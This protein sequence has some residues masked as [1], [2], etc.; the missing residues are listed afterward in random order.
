MAYTNAIYYLDPDNGVDAR[1]SLSPVTVSN[2]SGTVT[3]CTY[4]GHGL[5]TGAIVTLSS[6]TAWLNGAWR[7]TVVDADNFDL[8]DAE[9]QATA[10]A[11]GTV[12][13]HGGSSKADAWKTVQSGATAARIQP[14]DTIR[15]I[16]SPD[17]VVIGD[18]T[19]T[20]D[21]GE[22]VWTT[23][24]VNLVIDDCETAWTGAT[25]VTASTNTTRRKSGT[26]G[27]S[28]LPATA[29]TTGKI[30]H[31]ALPAT[32][33][34][35]AYQ[36]VSLWIHGGSA[37][38]VAANA[39]TLHLC[40]DAEGDVPIVSL[41]LPVHSSA[42]WAVV[43]L[44]AGAALPSAVASLS[45]SASVDP[46]S[47]TF[48]LDNIV[49]CKAPGAADCVTHMHAIG[50]ATVGEPEWYAIGALTD[51]GATIGGY[52]ASE[53]GSATT[54][55][56]PY[57]GTTETVPTSVLL[58]ITT[59]VASNER[60]IQDIGTDAAPITISGGWDRT[61]MS[62]Q[63]GVTYF[64][65]RHYNAAA[66]DTNNKD[67]L[68]FEKI[69]GLNFTTAVLLNSGGDNIDARLE[70]AVG[71]VAVWSHSSL[72]AGFQRLAFT[73]AHGM[74]IW[75]PFHTSPNPVAFEV[76]GTRIHGS[77]VATS[78]AALSPSDGARHYIDRIDN[79]GGY[80]ML[81][82]ITEGQA[83]D[84][85]GTTFANNAGTT[86][87]RLAS[88]AARLWDCVFADTAAVTAAASDEA[89]L[90]STRDQGIANRHKTY[91]RYQLVSSDDTVRQTPSGL[92]WRLAV[93]STTVYHSR[94]PATLSLGKIAVRANQLCTIGCS[95][96]R[97]DVGLTLGL[98]L[99]ARQ[100]PGLAEEVRA[101][102]TAAADTWQEVTVSFTPTV[103]G[104]VEVEGIG[105]GGTTYS[106][107]FDN[108][109]AIQE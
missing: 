100:I 99:R 2:P 37:P 11:S 55:P 26:R 44:D 73:Y 67:W 93:L 87:V 16:A 34:L 104:V 36:Q 24:G 18:A 14:G 10:D 106:G 23:P 70:Q 25:N 58:G 20:D 21:S 103:D 30:A 94:S 32:L 1:A 53:P 59:G 19:W 52:Y 105:W 51:T 61:D 98:R 57:R 65:G 41:P 90:Y 75:T 107:W 71:C 60:Q 81:V 54:A 63:S 86:D 35:S 95:L 96:R 22:I 42:S 29:F 74:P 48:Y 38:A 102:M 76:Y 47:G 62:T 97:S 80:G 85:Y 5:V 89:R 69:G 33:D 66:L 49:A 12:T 7:I 4:A 8:D 56:R 27:A 39:M 3:R 78:G 79:A 108:L 13:P 31:R 83:A 40:S 92:S 101:L 50:K 45:L 17:P 82:Q 6:F 15:I 88:G 77:C 84:V 72:A 46:S 109:S 9:W 28:F 64:N 43:V 91:G 68:V